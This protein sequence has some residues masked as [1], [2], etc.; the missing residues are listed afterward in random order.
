VPLPDPDHVAPGPGRP[1]EHSLATTS[2][3]IYATLV[4]LALTIPRGL[5]NWSR[6]FDPNPLQEA[7]L[8]FAQTVQL[9]SR[10]LGLNLP[11]AKARELFLT[12]TG[13]QDD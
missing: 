3:V 1:Q 11:Y 9:G 7:A 2:I 13:K 4:L 5:V 6:N 8:R 12:L 10:Q